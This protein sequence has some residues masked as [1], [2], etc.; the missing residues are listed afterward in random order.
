MLNYLIFTPRVVSPTG[1]APTVERE[2]VGAVPTN[3]DGTIHDWFIFSQGFKNERFGL[4]G[5]SQG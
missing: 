2:L 3:M 4:S 5:C 1:L